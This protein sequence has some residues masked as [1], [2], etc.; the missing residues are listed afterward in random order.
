MSSERTTCKWRLYVLFTLKVSICRYRIVPLMPICRYCIGL[1]TPICRYCFGSNL[2]LEITPQT[3]QIAYSNRNGGQYGSSNREGASEASD[4]LGLGRSNFGQGRV[5]R[6]RSKPSKQPLG[7]VAR[8]VPIEKV[9]A[10]RAMHSDW[11]RGVAG[12]W[13]RRRREAAPGEVQLQT[14]P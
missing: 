10:K 1:L 11:A 13:S 8:G 6:V 9:R 5:F 2:A 12:A 4:A 7:L 14:R 3:G